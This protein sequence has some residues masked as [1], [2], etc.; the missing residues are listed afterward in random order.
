[1]EDTAKVYEI[2]RTEER[3]LAAAD[4]RAQVNLIQEV[5]KAVMQNGQ[6]YGKIP[7]AGDKP[8]LLKPGAEKIMATF[9][10]SADPVVEDISTMDAIRYRVKCNLIS[11]SGVFKGAGIGECSTDE[12]KFKWRASACPE[13]FAETPDDRK[14]VK[15]KKGF[16]DKPA[17]QIMQIRTEP[18]DL[19]NTVLKMA[20]KRALVDG[21][22]TVTGTSDIFTQDI[23]DMP[24][25]LLNRAAPPQDKPPIRQPG[26][27]A[28][29]GKKEEKKPAGDT[30]TV[31][32]VIESITSAEGT[33]AK[34]PWTRYDIT[35]GGQRFS[36]FSDTTADLAGSAKDSPVTI[37][38]L[39]GQRGNTIKTLTISEERQPGAEG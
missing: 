20:K 38:Y 14:R 18:A 27:K 2:Q 34:G 8:T 39:E 5:M 33:S 4:L 32:G 10:L 7:G 19:A 12:E 35:V 13:E 6:H 23:E 31:S 3:P 25:E 9:R 16:G 37:E 21:V 36:T 1:M 24:A 22:L 26:K 15:W 11:L 17:Y 30:K 29:E 28:P